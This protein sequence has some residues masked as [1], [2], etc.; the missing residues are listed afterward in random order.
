MFYA[1][2]II[3][4]AN[5][6]RHISDIRLH[7]KNPKKS[8]SEALNK[9]LW[10]APNTS[11]YYKAYKGLPLSDY[12]V[13]TKSDIID[14]FEAFKSDKFRDKK[15]FKMATSGST[16]IP[17]VVLQDKNK[18]VRNTADTLYF[19]KMAGIAIGEKLVYIKLWVEKNKKS[20]LSLFAQ[21][22][23]KH[24]ILD[25]KNDQLEHLVERLKNHK[26]KKN[27]IVYP[28]F[29]EQFCHYTSNNIKSPPKI[30][31]LITISEKL[32][33][34][35][36]RSAENQFGAKVY[37]R[38]SNM[39][40]GIIA[41]QDS[42]SRHYIVNTASY[43]V[44]LL[45][46]EKDTVVTEGEIGRIVVTDLY[47]YAMPMIRYDTG[48]MAIGDTLKDGRQV[49]TK[50]FGRK[51]DLV[52]DTKGNIISPHVF[53]KISHFS[54]HKQFQFIQDGERSYCFKLNTTKEKTD[55]TGMITHFKKYLGDDATFSFVYVDEIPLLASGKRKKVLNRLPNN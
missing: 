53:Y 54:N 29:L 19:S 22:I 49:F 10:H 55:E 13:I 4:G 28:S 38:Y 47:N 9:L 35:E 52:F 8:R 33:E 42:T 39:E 21:N 48:D 5:V 25:Y 50:I 46:P 20:R 51:M 40:N 17:L 27:M 16:G 1:V 11:Q 26:G 12:P 23:M 45:H 30:G 14:N 15:L 43:I 32:N 34:F 3:R 7:F 18:K 6:T 37:E 31:S 2:D 41:Q 36:R 44:E 24:N